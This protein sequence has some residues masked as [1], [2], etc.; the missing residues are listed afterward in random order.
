MIA[1][2]K[3]RGAVSSI[4]GAM[5]I[6]LTSVVA[7][8]QAADAPQQPVQTASRTTST[9]AAQQAPAAPQKE[10]APQAKPDAA[11]RT[12]TANPPASATRQTAADPSA[13]ET[14]SFQIKYP[15]AKEV[16]AFIN[17]APG[18]GLLSAAGSV[19][20]DE[21]TNTLM[22]HDTANNIAAI[23]QLVARLD[24]PVQQILLEAQFAMLDEGFI[25][26][27]MAG[28]SMDEKV[29][30]AMYLGPEKSGCRAA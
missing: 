10:V 22:V 28:G 4:F 2:F 29:T 30:P 26:E 3:P 11:T 14:E 15:M 18:S 25:Q 23:R 5:L 9:T 7:V 19:A 21:R 12:R 16:A 6:A 13:L 20:V 17:S 8:T 1:H 27:L 24:A